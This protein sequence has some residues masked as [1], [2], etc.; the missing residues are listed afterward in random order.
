MKK[1]LMI[2]FAFAASSACAS[3]P[4]PLPEPGSAGA[5]VYAS[6][7]GVCHSVP[8]PKRHTYEQWKHMV[9]VMDKAREHKDMDPL[10][11][12]ERGSILEY[13]KKHSR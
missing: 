1:A 11:D 4:T 8:H 12:E 6:R 13:L 10:T 2:L 7:C 5:G 3:A 9:R